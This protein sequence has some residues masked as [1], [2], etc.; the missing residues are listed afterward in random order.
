VLLAEAARLAPDG[1]RAQATGGV[2][3]FGQVGALLLPLVYSG[4]LALTGKHG[5]GFALSTV[6]AFI[7]GVLLLRRKPSAE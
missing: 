6:P 2:L 3:S 1:L 4:T 7:V 5:L